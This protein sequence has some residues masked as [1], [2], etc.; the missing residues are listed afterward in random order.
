MEFPTVCVIWN[1]EKAWTVMR[2]DRTVLIQCGTV[3]LYRGGDRPQFPWHL[4]SF[5][6]AFV[7][8]LP[9]RSS[10]RTTPKTLDMP[11][12]LGEPFRALEGRSE[13]HFWPF[14]GCPLARV[15]VVVVWLS[16]L[17]GFSPIIRTGSRF[18]G[19]V[20]FF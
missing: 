20:A 4:T 7:L 18:L 1:S 17:S 14:V 11:F 15:T 8:K 19:G 6:P 3:I 2:V 9:Y 10:S 12:S 16:P 5:S 13:P